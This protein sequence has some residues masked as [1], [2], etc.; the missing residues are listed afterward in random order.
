MTDL[1]ILRKFKNFLEQD[2]LQALKRNKLMQDLLFL[3][4]ILGGVL[5]LAWNPKIIMYAV[6]A[7]G[8]IFVL[9]FLFGTIALV[10]EDKRQMLNELNKNYKKHKE[11]K[12]G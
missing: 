9:S 10:I 12:N 3:G 1:T 11:N 5:F 8:I 2:G 6:I 7:F 4:I